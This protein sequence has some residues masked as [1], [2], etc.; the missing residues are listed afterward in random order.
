MCVQGS[1]KSPWRQCS[2]QW[3]WSSDLVT[4]LSSR[5]LR[6]HTKL[7]TCSPSWTVVKK[8]AVDNH[9]AWVIMTWRKLSTRRLTT[10]PLTMALRLE[11]KHR[12]Q[13]IQIKLLGLWSSST[14]VAIHQTWSQR[15]LYTS[16]RLLWTASRF[17]SLVWT[18][19]PWLTT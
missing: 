6:R 11:E 17:N 5:P 14:P 2:T 15:T 1:T 10:R 18:H 3:C 16:A 12:T 7:T 8:T 4:P 19:S 13:T 9:G